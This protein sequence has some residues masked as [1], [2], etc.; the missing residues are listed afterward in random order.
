MEKILFVIPAMNIGGAEKSLVEL[1]NNINYEKYKVDLFLLEGEG[2]LLKEVN[3]KVTILKKDPICSAFLKNISESID[4]LIKY[5]RF[6]LLAKR[7]IVSVPNKL[8]VNINISHLTWILLKDEVRNCLGVYDYAIAY[9]QGV[10]EYYVVDKIDARKKI[11]WM[12]TSFRY[13][14]KK[15]KFEKTYITQYNKIVCVSEAAKTDFIELFPDKK[16]QTYVFKN[17]INKQKIRSL[18]LEKNPIPNDGNFHIVSVGRLHE[19]KGYDI[20]IEAFKNF[21]SK[22]PKSCFHIVGDGPLKE[23]L[24]SQIEKSGLE[25]VCFL[26]GKTTNPYCYMKQAD[27]ILQSSRYEG[28]CI[29]LAEAKVLFKPIITTDFFGAREQIKNNETG[30]IAECNIQSIFNALERVYTDTNLRRSFEQNLKE[31]T[32]TNDCLF[33]SI[34]S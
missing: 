26:E 30:I 14:S 16:E 34:L 15:D 5:R 22:F 21:H 18:S 2:T 4:Y 31:E 20:A 9:L 1:L 19:S 12:H 11:F 28:Y 3:P 27:V 17:I 24:K 33:K 8:P 23:K 7:I 13:H 32:E 10:T 25:K 6:K 29:V